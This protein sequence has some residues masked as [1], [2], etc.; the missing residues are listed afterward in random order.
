MLRHVLVCMSVYVCMQGHVPLG[1]DVGAGE[2]RIIWKLMREHQKPCIWIMGG[3]GKGPAVSRGTSLSTFNMCGDRG[4]CGTRKVR[5][6]LVLTPRKTV[7][8]DGRL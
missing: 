5:V 4:A 7:M 1:E 3:V 6:K 8:P 2:T